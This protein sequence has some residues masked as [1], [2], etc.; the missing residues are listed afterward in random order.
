MLERLNVDNIKALE[1]IVVVDWKESKLQDELLHKEGKLRAGD[2]WS[3]H[4]LKNAKV[5]V[6]IG[7]PLNSG[8]AEAAG[9]RGER[10][11][12]ITSFFDSLI[13]FWLPQINVY[14]PDW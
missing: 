3:E 14:E 9:L 10:Y 11:S 13:Y 2:V 12:Y 7:H 8:I 1:R 4:I 6:T 5:T